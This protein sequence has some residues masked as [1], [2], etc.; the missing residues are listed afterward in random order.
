MF[1]GL[2]RPQGKEIIRLR[3][4]RHRGTTVDLPLS[5]IALADLVQT[6]GLLHGFPAEEIGSQLSALYPKENLKE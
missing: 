6:L 1:E 3:F 5:A 2:V 4:S